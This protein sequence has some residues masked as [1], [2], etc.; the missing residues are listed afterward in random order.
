MIV[1]S[2]SGVYTIFIKLVPTCA[3]R[4]GLS[5]TDS[6]DAKVEEHGKLKRGKY[7]NSVWMCD[8]C[9]E[10]QR[11]VIMINVQGRLE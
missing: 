11:T 2:K 7:V 1:I 9:T 4:C 6:L 5:V 10:A 3:A 8:E